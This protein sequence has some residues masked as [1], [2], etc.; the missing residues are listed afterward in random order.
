[1]AMESVKRAAAASVSSQVQTRSAEPVRVE[2]RETVSGGTG[3]VEAASTMTGGMQTGGTASRSGEQPGD[4][5]AER[6]LKG[7]V[8]YANKQIKHRGKTHC[9]FS[10]H[11]ETKRIS[12]TVKDAAT[13]EVIREI[14]AEETLQ[15]ME[16]MWE[17]AGILVDEKR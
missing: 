10:Y 1:M 4:Q 13:Q 15:M 5:E 6:R 9:E 7:A 3:Y 16:K 17:L 11:E 8:D 2:G 12:I 14:P